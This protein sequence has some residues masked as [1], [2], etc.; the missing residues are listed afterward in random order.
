MDNLAEK[1][2]SWSVTPI[3]EGRPD[4]TGEQWRSAG[5]AR[6][7]LRYNETLR[8]FTRVFSTVASLYPHVAP[9][10]AVGGVSTLIDLATGL[11]MPVTIPAS[12]AFRFLSDSWSFTRRMVG[13]F[14][15]DTIFV[16]EVYNE[17]LGAYYVHRIT[18]WDTGLLSLLPTAHSWNTTITNIDTGVL[19][20]FWSHG[21]VQYPLGTKESPKTKT[22]QC[23]KCGAKRKVSNDTTEV[24]CN[25][26]G[27]TTRYAPVVDWRTQRR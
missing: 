27:E 4:Y 25:K 18:P 24:K 13:R 3:G 1:T 14:Y 8:T 17:T 2:R 15:F 11:P 7:N 12:F 9:P 10:L 21:I 20:G 19:E 23:R 26:C 6:Y 22:V 5:F 16:G